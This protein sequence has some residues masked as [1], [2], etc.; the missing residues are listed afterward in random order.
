[1]NFK[2]TQI[3]PEK[4]KGYANACAL[5]LSRSLNYGGVLI[6]QSTKAYKVNGTDNKPY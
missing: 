2:N 4:P 6:K 1:M 5:R 3:P